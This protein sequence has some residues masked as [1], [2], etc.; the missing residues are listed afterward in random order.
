MPAAPRAVDRDGLS[1]LEPRDAGADRLDPA[2]VLVAEGEGRVERQEAG[3]ELV[4]EVEVR[5]A[6]TRATDPD[7]H[8][9]GPGFGVRDLF[10]LRGVLPGR[11]P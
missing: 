8:F 10:D 7:E 4:H 5:V 2:R 11:Q 6:R 3:R 1:R 9:A